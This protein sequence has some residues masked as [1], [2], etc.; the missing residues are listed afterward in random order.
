MKSTLI[1]FLP[2]KISEFAL[3]L[4]NFHWIISLENMRTSFMDGP[5][6]CS[7][8]LKFLLN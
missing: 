3:F 8:G 7:S 6:H 5:F 2:I 1:V 4:T